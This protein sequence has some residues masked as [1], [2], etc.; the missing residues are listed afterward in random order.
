MS[1][2][3]T[4]QYNPID[5]AKEVGKR[6]LREFYGDPFADVF[7][8]L[9][10]YNF[11]HILGTVVGDERANELLSDE[12]WYNEFVREY[13][14]YWSKAVAWA[15]SMTIFRSAVEHIAPITGR[16]KSKIKELIDE[17]KRAEDRRDLY[18]AINDIGEFVGCSDSCLDG[19]Y[20]ALDLIPDEY[21]GYVKDELI[22]ALSDLEW[23]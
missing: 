20:K 14:K 16:K 18:W 13:M 19:V 4:S 9:D 12:G 17:V 7:A 15:I 3:S 1:I 2:G 8:L 5:V 6:L 21:I 22:S 10:E 23:S 11:M